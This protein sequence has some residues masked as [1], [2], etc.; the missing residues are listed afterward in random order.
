MSD[1]NELRVIRS[2][3][4]VMERKLLTALDG[5][6]KVAIL[7]T[8]EDLDL[9]IS[10]LGDSIQKDAQQYATDLKKLRDAAFPTRRP[11]YE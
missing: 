2:A 1:G 3:R 6:S 7:A 4:T 8:K 9:M 10:A 11:P 5:N